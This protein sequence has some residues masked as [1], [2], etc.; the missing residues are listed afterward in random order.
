MPS[1]VG[2]EKQIEALLHH[3]PRR[4]K[5]YCC[6]RAAIPEWRASSAHSLMCRARGWTSHARGNFIT[7][8]THP[9]RLR[10]PSKP[11]P[12]PYLLTLLLTG[13]HWWEVILLFQQITRINSTTPIQLKSNDVVFQLPMAFWQNDIGILLSVF[14]WFH[15]SWRWHGH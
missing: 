8:L 1:S 14:P 9:F 2:E 7:S 10:S 4:G 6:V 11:Q 5:G 12:S 3:A 15:T 13:P